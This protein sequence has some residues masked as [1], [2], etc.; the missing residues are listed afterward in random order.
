[1]RCALAS[2]GFINENIQ[3]NKNV[4]IDTMTRYAKDADIVIFGEAFLQGFYGATFETEHDETL[5][6]N[7]NDSVIK[8]LC[9]AA[10]KHRIAVSFG[11]IE[12]A[13][14]CFY[15]SQMTI[16]AN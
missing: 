10:K 1:M 3:Y 4:I 2:M 9:S 15:S 6:L 13:D 7:Q 16:D 14:K 12:K 5:A 8:E 11:F